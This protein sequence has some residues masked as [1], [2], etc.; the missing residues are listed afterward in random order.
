MYITA[1]LVRFAVAL[2]T[3]CFS[4]PQNHYSYVLM[5]DG[6]VQFTGA[7]FLPPGGYYITKLLFDVSGHSLAI[8]A[9][10]HVLLGALIPLYIVRLSQTLVVGLSPAAANAGGWLAVAF[11]PLVFLSGTWRYMLFPVLLGLM[12]LDFALRRSALGSTVVGSLLLLTRPDFYFGGLAVIL[13]TPA[14]QL[15]GSRKIA[16]VAAPVMFLWLHAAVAGDAG[17]TKNL[18]YNV[19]AGMNARSRT[20]LIN[21]GP[22]LWHVEVTLADHVRDE[23]LHR[24]NA[25]QF[26]QSNPLAALEVFVFKLAKL[27]DVRRD[28]AIMQHP[29]ENIIYT[30]SL[31]AVLVLTLF[32]MGQLGWSAISTLLWVMVGYAL[33]MLLV[34]SIDRSRMLFQ[35]LWLVPCGHC[36]HAALAAV[37]AHAESFVRLRRVSHLTRDMR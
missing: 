12:H 35:G 31:S 25:L 4:D 33:P 13:L 11:P 24:A 26:M 5:P 30:L 6:E 34:F 28:G 14:A 9:L 8:F 7:G 32:G 27:V 3:H 2:I 18:W 22:E 19:D 20:A 23:D 29:L 16:Q 36:V 15:S 1:V 17:R 21:Y 10:L 37:R